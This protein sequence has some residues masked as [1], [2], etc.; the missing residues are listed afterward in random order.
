[1]TDFND[2]N[3]NN[4]PVQPETPAP[5]QAPQQPYYQP[6][7]YTQQQYPQYQ[8]PTEQAQ[9]EYQPPRYTQ[10]YQQPYGEQQPQY[11]QQPYQQYQQ[12]VYQP[13]KVYAPKSRIAAG[14][15]GVMLG[16]FGVHNFYLGRTGIAVAQ[17]L[18]ATIGGV[19]TCGLGT[20][21]TMVWGLVEGIQLISGKTTVDGHGLPFVD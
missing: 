6:P 4:T 3:Q 7:Q 20:C 8:Q 14:I 11:Q 17:L 1:M 18:I 21:A 2:N 13:P 9:G 5:E 15:L 12:P 10:Q 16:T 19:L